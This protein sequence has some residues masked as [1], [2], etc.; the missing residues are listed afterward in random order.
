MAA[1][2]VIPATFIKVNNYLHG[3]I[4]LICGI[5]LAGNEGIGEVYRIDNNVRTLLAQTN[6]LGKDDS[7]DII[8]RANGTLEVDVSEADPGGSG[9]TCAIRTYIFPNI[10]PALT[11]VS[12]GNADLWIRG[13]VRAFMIGLRDLA[14]KFINI[15]P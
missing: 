2:T 1:I 8:V 3:D 12:S 9:T 5:R 15:I 13:Q 11:P 7:I 4:K 10:L 6:E 14:Q